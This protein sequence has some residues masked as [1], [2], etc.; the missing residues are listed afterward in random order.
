MEIVDLLPMEHFLVNAEADTSVGHVRCL[1]LV[2]QI[3]VGMVD[4]A[5][6]AEMDSDVNVLLFGVVANAP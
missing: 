4:H 5:S 2:N 6:Q 1:H 3:H